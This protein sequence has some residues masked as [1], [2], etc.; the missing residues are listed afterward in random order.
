MSCMAEMKVDEVR[1]PIC[2]AEKGQGK[3]EVYHLSPETILEGRYIVGKVLGY[4]GFGITYIG[5]DAQLERIVAIKEYFPTTF[6]TRRQEET[7][8]SIYNTQ[9]AEGQFKA[10]LKSFLEE[11]QTLAQFNGVEGIVDI[12]DTFVS[13][14]TAYI[15]MEYL[16]GN[17]AKWILNNQG[18]FDYEFAKNIIVSICDTLSVVHKKNI[19]HRDISPD[20]I[21]LTDDGRIKLLDFGAARYESAF[22]SK[23]LSVVLKSGFAPEEQ[24]RSKG[25]Q[26]SWSDVYAL[27]A[28]FYKMLTGQTPPDSMDRAIKDELIEPSKLGIELPENIENAILNALNVKKSD[29]IQTTEAFK[30]A[31]L[32]NNVQR[33]VVKQKTEKTGVPLVAKII[34][35]IGGGVLLALGV[36]AVTGGLEMEGE[37]LEDTFGTVEEVLSEDLPVE[38][39]DE[40]MEGLIF[41]A[42]NKSVQSE[43][44]YASDLESLTE[45]TFG[46]D[47]STSITSLDDLK[48]LVN[49][50]K[51]II[52]PDLPVDIDLSPLAEVDSLRTLEFNGFDYSAGVY[53]FSKL[54]E[55][56]QIET[57][58]LDHALFYFDEISKIQGIKHL[59]IYNEIWA[60]EF[61]FANFDAIATMTN[62]ESIKWH[63][64]A[65]MS[66]SFYPTEHMPIER[67]LELT[68]ESG[69]E[70]GYYMGINPNIS[71]A[72][73][74]TMENLKTLEFVGCGG[75]DISTLG[76]AT[77][78]TELTFNN[79]I[80]TNF[81]F[82]NDMTN[83]TKLT[84]ENNVWT[85]Q[86]VADLDNVQSTRT[87]VEISTGTMI[88]N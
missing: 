2:G 26:G 34:M 55:A 47:H 45:L 10:G 22:N 14:N 41:E 37:Q 61:T 15:I 71:L 21:Y 32:A 6:A 56:T 50:Q 54:S 19:I 18:A 49:L 27:A 77:N 11:A 17:D 35:G 74:A 67:T 87:D 86:G 38:F 64:V 58:I 84:V 70:T 51:I 29:R 78:I 48:H 81:G 69:A 85:D 57:L 28:T 4:G 31:L 39:A 9:D 73:L 72:P 5:F 53:D 59:E 75:L 36:F 46:Y 1:C 83:L 52:T 13:N 88:T 7:H 16:K 33:V 25:D 65:D 30:E 79:G 80:I 82:V 23:S 24:Y 66:T 63:D 76:A 60:H 8:L 62:L 40:S 68:L 43:E 12:Y 3:K 44:V 42:L 20:N